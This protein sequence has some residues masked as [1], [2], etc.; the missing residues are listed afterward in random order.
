MSEAET[1]NAA[2]IEIC[3]S[4]RSTEDHHSTDQNT[5]HHESL[6]TAVT[7]GDGIQQCLLLSV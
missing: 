6:P 5:A 4:T 3:C 2:N 7:A 1:T